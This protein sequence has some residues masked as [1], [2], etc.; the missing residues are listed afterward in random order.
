MAIYKVIAW[1]I[2]S[3]QGQKTIHPVN[4]QSKEEADKFAEDYRSEH[5]GYEV[6]VEEFAA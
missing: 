5:P 6:E 1:P 4:F 3:P 2:A